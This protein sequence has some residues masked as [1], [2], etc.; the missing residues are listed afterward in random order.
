MLVVLG[1]AD[2]GGDDQKNLDVSRSRAESVI[3]T[4]RAQLG[5][6]GVMHPIGMGGQNLIDKENRDKNRVVEIW[7][8]LP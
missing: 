2:Q 1:Y 7:A 5:P 3:R 8:V 6:K 4:L